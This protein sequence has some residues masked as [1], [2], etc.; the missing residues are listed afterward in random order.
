MDSTVIWLVVFG[1]GFYLGWKINDVFTRITFA[2]M[3]EEAGVTNKDLDKFLT[4]WRPK[5]EAESQEE[6]K[7]FPVIEIKV[8][9]HND[10]LY[11]YRA[12]NDEFLGQGSNKDA[13]LEHLI[14]KFKS[15][16]KVTLQV[17]EGKEYFNET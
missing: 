16:D 5:M 14:N 1:A 9:K 8:E 6:S 12:D 2:K 17:T 13:L 4:H 11:A 3:L 15:A 10:Q 7:D